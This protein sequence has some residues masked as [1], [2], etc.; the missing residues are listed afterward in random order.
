MVVG[1][2]PTNRKRKKKEILKIKLTSMA[3]M[4]TR[5]DASPSLKKCGPGAQRGTEGLLSVAWGV[6]SMGARQ[7]PRAHGAS[8]GQLDSA[9]L[10]PA[11][12]R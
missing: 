5:C 1:P 9:V 7:M 11:D 2:E 6:V 10:L 8:V 12:C 4:P 3:A